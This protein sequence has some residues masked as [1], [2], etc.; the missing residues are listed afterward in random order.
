MLEAMNGVKNEENMD[1]TKA[2]RRTDR[3]CASEA[4]E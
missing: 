4:A 2:V 3:S 1:M